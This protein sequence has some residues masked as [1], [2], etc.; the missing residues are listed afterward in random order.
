M[1]TRRK[2]APTCADAAKP[3]E[4]RNRRDGQVAVVTPYYKENDDIL[5]QCHLSVLRQSYPCTHILVA[6]GHPKPLFDEQPKTMHITL[7]QANGD[8]GNR[9]RAIGGILAESYGFDAVAYLDA[10]NWYDL[11]HIERLIAA[12]Q[13]NDQIIW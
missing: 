6:D 10:D 1:P 11:A 7:P 9:P 3:L 5:R 4:I 2:I 8:M 13:A 12:H